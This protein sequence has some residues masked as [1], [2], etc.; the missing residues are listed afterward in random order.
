MVAIRLVIGAKYS[1]CS[2]YKWYVFES[3]L[4]KIFLKVHFFDR[5]RLIRGT[6]KKNDYHFDWG[7]LTSYAS[8]ILGDLLLTCFCNPLPI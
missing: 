1:C 7:C 8:M 5:V 6:E 2:G 3:A 4:D